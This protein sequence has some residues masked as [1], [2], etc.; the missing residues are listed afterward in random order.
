M[1][2]FQH[3]SSLIEN[4]EVAMQQIYI[5]ITMVSFCKKIFCS[6]LEIHNCVWYLWTCDV[7]PKPKCYHF[8]WKETHRKLHQVDNF[9]LKSSYK[10]WQILWYGGELYVVCDKCWFVDGPLWLWGSW[11]YQVTITSYRINLL[12]TYTQTHTHFK[13]SH[14]M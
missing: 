10:K 7:S 4:L 6:F 3:Y 5:C 1:L 8:S 12:V 11:Y 13:L 14:K 9:V 2:F